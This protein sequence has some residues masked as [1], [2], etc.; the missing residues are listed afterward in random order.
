LSAIRQAFSFP[1]SSLQA[2]AFQSGGGCTG[3][4]ERDI[5]IGSYGRPPARRRADRCILPGIEKRKWW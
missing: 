2:P 3:G 1:V 5:T 4:G